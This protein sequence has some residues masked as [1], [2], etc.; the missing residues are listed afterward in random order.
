MHFF[1]YRYRSPARTR[2]VLYMAVIHMFRSGL[3]ANRYR[4]FLRTVGFQEF[5][6]TLEWL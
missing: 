4:F 3:W 2:P 5:F 6:A 1:L